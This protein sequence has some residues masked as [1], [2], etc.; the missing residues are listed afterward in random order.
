MDI[1][2]NKIETIIIR[3]DER[4]K[5]L[6]IDITEIKE[7]IK[8]Y[9]RVEERVSWLTKFYWILTTAVIMGLAGTLFALIKK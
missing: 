1:S 7:K 9:K 6:C 8:D 3:I 2:N 5:Q 4:T